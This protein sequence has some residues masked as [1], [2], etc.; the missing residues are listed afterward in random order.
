MGCV[1]STPSDKGAAGGASQPATAPPPDLADIPTRTRSSSFSE[2]TTHVIS[3]D[4]IPLR[5]PNTTRLRVWQDARYKTKGYGPFQ[6]PIRTIRMDSR[7]LVAAG[8]DDFGIRQYDLPSAALQQVYLGH[9][10]MVTC[11]QFDG[12]R[13]LSCSADTTVRVWDMNRGETTGLLIDHTKGVNWLH[14]NG[15][16]LFTCSKDR[17]I[18]LWD[19]RANK[20]QAVLGLDDNGHEDDVVMLQYERGKRTLMTA[21]YDGTVKVWDTRTGQA[22]T[23]VNHPAA[24]RALKFDS[25]LLVTAALDNTVRIYNV[26][27]LMLDPPPLHTF[28]E[29]G[30]THFV[31]LDD[32][33]IVYGAGS[34]IKVLERPKISACRQIQCNSG[35]LL[36]ACFSDSM[37]VSASADGKVQAYDFDLKT[38]PS[39]ALMPA[40]AREVKPST[41]QWAEQNYSVQKIGDFEGKRTAVRIDDRF[42]LCDGGNDYSIYQFGIATSMLRQRFKGHT[43]LIRCIQFDS[44]KMLSCSGDKSVRH[45]DMHTGQCVSVMQEHKNEVN[46]LQYA[47]N[48]MATCSE[49][50][51]VFLWD[52]RS[53]RVQMALHDHKDDIY[54][55]QYSQRANVLMTCSFDRTVK[56]WDLRR[57]DGLLASI[58]HPD[59]VVAIQFDHNHLV[60]SCLDNNLRIF[61]R[62]DLRADSEPV[63]R[64]EVPDTVHSL[65]FDNE[66][67]FFACGNFVNVVDRENERVCRTL[68]EH[69]STVFRIQLHNEVLATASFDSTVRI[70]KL[71]SKPNARRASAVSSDSDV[72]TSESASATS[73]RGGHKDSL[74]ASSARRP[75][76]G[77]AMVSTRGGEARRMSTL[78]SSERSSDRRLSTIGSPGQRI[79]SSGSHYS[80]SSDPT[81]DSS[82]RR[83]GTRI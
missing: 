23:T 9:R 39:A 72:S 27:S 44:G 63:Q 11:V 61:S 17:S 43:D 71:D 8:A 37:L 1:N 48:I 10:D 38:M 65:A 54:M 57:P 15:N 66:K 28:S 14:F 19:L 40:P 30:R 53:H 25:E 64:I 47:H 34:S 32:D 6:G 7:R 78:G 5:P 58:E 55:L 22:H 36:D 24:V 26:H 80:L 70:W 12:D 69:D 2:L 18:R 62:E 42:M 68:R 79:P 35:E 77:S 52:L 4:P 33:L 29:T 49:D 81:T 56:C 74:S 13:M 60:T 3:G 21:S 59:A 20:Q 73:G 31:D 67:L 45:W 82:R 46:W 41:F 76:S 51:K 83:P 75:S 16:V 50:T